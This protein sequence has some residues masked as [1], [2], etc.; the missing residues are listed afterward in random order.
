MQREDSMKAWQRDWKI[1]AIEKMNPHWQDLASH[2]EVERV[3][4]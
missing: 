3:S 1:N 4:I 2:L